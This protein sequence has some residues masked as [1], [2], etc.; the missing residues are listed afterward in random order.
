MCMI[1][2][3]IIN[4]I[5]SEVWHSYDVEYVNILKKGERKKHLVVWMLNVLQRSCLKICFPNLST[6]EKSE[7]VRANIHSRR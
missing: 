4:I 6:M 7:S 3:Y 5:Y 1:C 2:L